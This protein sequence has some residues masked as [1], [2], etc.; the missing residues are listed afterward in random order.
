METLTNPSRFSMIQVL[1][2]SVTHVV[3]LVSKSS[4]VV[5][6]FL[7]SDSKVEMNGT[8]KVQYIG[9]TCDFNKSKTVTNVLFEKYFRKIL[10]FDFVFMLDLMFYSLPLPIRLHTGSSKSD[11]TL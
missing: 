8:K 9:K 4:A 2:S 5:V 3:S 10:S 11:S 7:M 6:L 1:D